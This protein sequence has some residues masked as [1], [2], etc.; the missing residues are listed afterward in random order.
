MNFPK[1]SKAYNILDF[2]L[3]A[4]HVSIDC[5]Y[6][7][8]YLYHHLAIFAQLV[9]NN[10]TTTTTNNVVG[11]RALAVPCHSTLCWCISSIYCLWWSLL[12]L[13]WWSYYV[14]TASIYTVT[15]D[16]YWGW[17][18][19][20]DVAVVRM[21]ACEWCLLMMFLSFWSM[22]F[23]Y[24]CCGQSA[25]FHVCELCWRALLSGIANELMGCVPLAV[26]KIFGLK[27]RWNLGRF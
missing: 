16:C 20:G 9:W 15:S 23:M 21:T 3:L 1:P 12:L 5:S 24:Y 25:M 13:L 11:I 6:H 26:L 27:T 14:S 18:S 2:I 8:L 10:T 17:W 22:L 7:P 19:G 4:L